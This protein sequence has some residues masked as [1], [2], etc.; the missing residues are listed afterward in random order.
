MAE[1]LTQRDIEFLKQLKAKDRLTSKDMERIR[2]RAKK[3]GLRLEDDPSNR[4]M[5]EDS[6]K[7]TLEE[8]FNTLPS[9][10]RTGFEKII[11]IIKKIFFILTSLFN[12]NF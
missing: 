7:P 6:R 8:Q 9:L 10:L 3:L 2:E 11:K 4:R 1:R 5:F 12:K